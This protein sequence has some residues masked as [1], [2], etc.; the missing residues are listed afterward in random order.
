[1]RVSAAMSISVLGRIRVWFF[2]LLR[3]WI[4]LLFFVLVL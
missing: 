4:C 1:M 3:V 2:V